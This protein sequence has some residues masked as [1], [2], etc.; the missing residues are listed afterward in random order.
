MLNLIMML[1]VV[2]P[3]IQLV[4]LSQLL[5]VHSFVTFGYTKSSHLGMVLEPLFEPA[6]M[7]VSIAL[8]S[9]AAGAASQFPRIKELERELTITKK[10]LTEVRQ[11]QSCTSQM[12]YVETHTHIQSSENDFFPSTTVRTGV[13]SEDHRAGGKALSHGS[14]V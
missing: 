10:A 13:G 12:L 5:V 8:L 11:P 4:F 1:R 14:R 9:A 3:A 2:L 6:F 7:D